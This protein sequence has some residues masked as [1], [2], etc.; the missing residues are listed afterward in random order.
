MQREGHELKE[1][2]TASRQIMDGTVLRVYC[3]EVR[4]PNGAPARR[5]LIRHVGAVCI[6]PVTDD[7]R[8][9]IER[10]YRYPVDRIIT[11]I[12]AG[13][14][15]DK[16]EDPLL[17]AQRELREETGLTASHWESLGIFY[18]APAYSDE[19]I[20]MFLAKGLHLGA[21]QLDADEFLEVT[22]VPLADLAEQILRGEIPDLKTQ[23]AV[24]RAYLMERGGK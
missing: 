12:P 10:Q 14:L 8:V 22:S 17:A 23:A 5:E 11:E 13:K 20:H 1:T 4:L 21:Q 3:D 19:T 7:G 24:L 16:Q 6:V 18:P 15:N 9:I 2:Q